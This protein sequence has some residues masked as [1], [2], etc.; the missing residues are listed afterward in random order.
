MQKN[1]L[2]NCYIKWIQELLL[3]LEKLRLA[4]YLEQWLKDYAYLNVSPSTA[5]GYA[6]II[7]NHIIPSL[8]KSILTQLK[9]EKIQKY[10]S[11]KLNNGRCDGE[12][13]LNPMTVKHHHVCLHTALQNAVK[14]GLLIRNPA[15][16]VT[17]PH[18]R[19][20]E[21]NI[22]N[23][24]DIHI[25]LEY[26]K[27]TQYY[28]LFYTAL[29]TGMRRSELLGLR[30]QDVD[31]LLLQL[32]VNRSLHQL[33]NRE[34]VFKQPKTEKSRRQIALSPSTALVLGDHRN[35]QEQLRKLHGLTLSD[36]DLV[37]SQDDGKPLLPN[38]V[39]HAWEKISE[40]NRFKGYPITRCKAYSCFFDV[41]AGYT[42][43]NSSRAFRSFNHIDNS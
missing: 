24:C 2:M 4:D 39:S 10:Y 33:A 27:S 11:D 19:R 26:A 18:T 7:H 34:I 16:A 28:A 37:F 12:G 30:W 35:N 29:F 31:L 14:L 25:F 3:S 20:T 22:M 43:E 9:P 13:G 40:T 21:M 42:P 32:S 15:D 8:G 36:N 1:A 5:D 17:P 41:K 23:E 6:S 38:S